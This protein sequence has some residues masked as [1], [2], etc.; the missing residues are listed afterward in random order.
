[1]RVIA[2]AFK[3]VLQ[4]ILLIF[5]VVYALNL[6]P[7]FAP[8]TWMVFSYIGFHYPNAN[9][10]LFAGVGAIA[11]T[12]GRVTLARIST[13]IIRKRILGEGARQNIDVIRER[14]TDR[15]K[16]TFSIFL[17]YAFTPLP[18]NYLFI[19]YGLTAMKL[20]RIAVPFFLGRSVSYI[21]WGATSSAVSRRLSLE[22][23]DVIS[24]MSLYFVATQ[25]LLISLVY[26]FTQIDWRALF[27]ERK[28]R[29]VHRSDGIANSP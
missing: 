5:L 1:M 8:P 29:W 16:L 12:L 22:S 2:V 6:I 7:A 27:N 13:M 15:P 26:A 11:A 14:L 10:I 23:T 4:H 28:L 24:Y 20:M 3:L 18:S 19:S 21:V 25:I 17:F 9:V